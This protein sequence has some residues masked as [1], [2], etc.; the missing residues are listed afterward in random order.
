VRSPAYDAEDAFR[1]TMGV[2]DMAIDRRRFVTIGSVTLAATSAAIKS[3]TGAAAQ[4]ATPV[5]SPV[6]S[7]PPLQS[8]SRQAYAD[9]LF[10]QFPMSEPESEGGQVIWGDISDLTTV[11]AMLGAD[12]PTNPFLSLVFE[13]LVSTSPID[14]QPVPG[15]AD[16]WERAE[17]GVTYTFRLNPDVRFHDGAPLTAADVEFSLQAQLNP[18]TGSQYTSAVAA[19][20]AS[21]RVIDDLTF[22]VVSNGPR[23]NFLFDFI[24]PVLPRHIWEGVPA[25]GWAADSGSNGQDPARVVGTGPFRFV[26]W[27]QGQS[28]TLERNPDYWDTVSGKV[29]TI[30]R[31]TLQVFPDETTLIQALRTGQVDFVGDVPEAE[32]EGLIA[33]NGIEVTTYP[34]FDFGF[35]FMNLDPDRSLYFQDREVREALFRAL[36]RQAIIDNIFLGF[37]EVAVGT[38]SLLSAAYAPERIDNPYTFDLDAAR[39]LLESAGWVDSDGDGIREKDGQPLSFGMTYTEGVTTYEQLVPYMQQQ[40]REVG[41]DMQPNPVPF[42]SLVEAITET[43]EFD[44]ALLGFSWVADPAQNVMFACDQYEGGFNAGRYCN[45]AYDEL[46]FAADRELDPERRLELLIQA[47]QIVWNDLPVGIIRFGEDTAANTDRLNNFYPNDY[48]N[49]TWSMPWAWLSQ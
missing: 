27:V 16:S 28:A 41:A 17:D 23:A 36:D 38:Q 20:V 42:P 48:T 8:V 21:F 46:A 22:E 26:E 6:A 7:Y 19:A 9:A 33:T 4:G 2:N 39:A 1:S 35:Y 34:T 40:W 13:Q 30:E 49:Q 5:A 37:G 29:P 12:Q 31:F 47:S 32:V 43:H 14:G 18:D 15:L 44:T 25:T 3:T 11:N 10:A 24:L 45:P